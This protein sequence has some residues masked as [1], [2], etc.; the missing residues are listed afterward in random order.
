MAGC[1][2]CRSSQAVCPWGLSGPSGHLG[3]SSSA[4]ASFV[5][6]RGCGGWAWAAVVKN[7]CLSQAEGDLVVH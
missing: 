2:L 6:G 1:L 5:D 4:V 7:S 3:Q